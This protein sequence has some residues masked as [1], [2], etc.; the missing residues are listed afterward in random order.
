M[1]F[2]FGFFP[3]SLYSGCKYKMYRK[4]VGVKLLYYGQRSV[5]T[6]PKYEYYTEIFSCDFM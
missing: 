1:Y 3:V 5:Y 6:Q 4:V 2:V